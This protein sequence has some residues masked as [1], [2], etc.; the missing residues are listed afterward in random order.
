MSWE[1][2]LIDERARKLAQVQV[3]MSGN[4][5]ITAAFGDSAEDVSAQIISENLRLVEE[6]DGILEAEKVGLAGA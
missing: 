1:R 2:F 4:V 6:I 5:T 3:L